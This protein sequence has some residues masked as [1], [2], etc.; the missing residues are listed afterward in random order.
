MTTPPPNCNRTSQLRHLMQRVNITSFKALSQ[1][2][3][4]S[5]KQI[6]QLRH[7]DLST[8]RLETVVQ[9][10]RVLQMSLAEFITVLQEGEA[11]DK[12]QTAEGEEKESRERGDFSL[13]N[14]NPERASRQAEDALLLQELRQEYDRLQAKLTQQREELWQEF[15]QSSLQ[16]LESLLL[17]LPTAI[18]AAQQN[19]Q[20]SA[21]KLLP[22]LRPIDGL[23]HH[24]GIEA[25]AIV[26]SEVPY[27]PQLHQLMDGTTD[28]GQPVRVR[29]IGYRQ[30]EKLLYRAKVSPV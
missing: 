13:A 21:I 24:W 27:D 12:Q 6:R 19:P 14:S 1:A 7:G 28:I 25:I 5:E 10:S 18:H 20:V 2:S 23:L 26:G 17:Q 15:Q 29:Y 30:G 11:D 3:G 16:V 4:V 8:A 9:I 22:L